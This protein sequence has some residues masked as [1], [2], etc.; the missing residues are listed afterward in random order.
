MKLFAIATLAL[1][2]SAGAASAT[3]LDNHNDYFAASASGG[4][5]SSSAFV[6]ND[7]PR[8]KA[9]HRIGIMKTARGGADWCQKVITLPYN[10]SVADRSFCSGQTNGDNF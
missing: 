3:V 10:Y 8:A 6:G 5:T 2:L 1:S 7:G 4:S 9:M